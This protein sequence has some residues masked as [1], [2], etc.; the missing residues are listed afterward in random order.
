MRID[1]Y[2][3]F[4]LTVIGIALVW[5]CVRDVLPTPVQARGEQEAVTITGIDTMSPLP[6]KIVAIERQQ[7]TKKV[8][9]FHNVQEY[10][11]WETI[12][13]SR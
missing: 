11:P 2:T 7:W 9:A 13:V 5:L 6:V 12:R 3:K 8:D 1:V 4:V 10:G